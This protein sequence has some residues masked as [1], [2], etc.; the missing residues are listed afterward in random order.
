MDR[1]GTLLLLLIGFVGLMDCLDGT[2]VAVALPTIASDMGVDVSTASWVSVAYF[3]M[4]AGTLILFGRIAKNTSIR[5][6]LLSGIAIFSISSLA[7]GLSSSF[8]MLIVSRIAQGIGAAM[9]GAT[10]PMCCVRFFPAHM[11]GYALAVVTIGYSVGAAVGPALGG[12]L[13]S[14]LSWHWIFYIN[15][16]IVAICLAFTIKRLPG[17]VDSMT[18]KIDYIG[19]AVLTALLVDILL[20]FEWV[21]T[22]FQVL[23]LQ[24]LLMVVIAIVIGIVFFMIEKHADD[25]VLAPKLFRNKTIVISM[26]IML[27]YGIAMLGT[28]SFIAMYMIY[29]YDIDTMEC[30]LMLLPLVFGMMIT[31]MG[32]GMLVA[33]TGYRLW[34]VIGTA[35]IAGSLL[36]L[37]TLGADPSKVLL[38]IYTFLF[39]L[40]LGCVQSIVM[41]AVQNNSDPREVG[42]TTSSVSLVRSIGSTTGT[43]IFSLIIS[44]KMD[45]EFAASIYNGMQEYFG[46][47]GTGLLR[48]ADMNLFP[49]LTDFVIGIFGDGI[50]LAFLIVGAVFLIAVVLSFFMDSKYSYVEKE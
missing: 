45:S 40:G 43:A 12:I 31:S 17:H 4:M 26:A 13:V 22:E 39:G 2:I 32:S 6:V 19:M 10:I 29:A 11:L 38:E 49:A 50:C 36:L 18:Q 35:I 46:L 7:C 27:L 41:S 23:S 37:S 25:P 34:T 1:R 3:M 42:M 28:L 5:L 14:S 33:K 30:G 9:M 47:Q 8:L 20:F 24:T 21:G 15:V 48:F 44:S 16:P